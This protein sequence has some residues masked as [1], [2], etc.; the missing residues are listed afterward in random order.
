M[1]SGAYPGVPGGV[2]CRFCVNSLWG[3]LKNNV[4]FGVTFQFWEFGN[5]SNF[6]KKIEVCGKLDAPFCFPLTETTSVTT[7]L[8]RASATATTMPSMDDMRTPMSAPPPEEARKPEQPTSSGGSGG[9]LWGWFWEILLREN[10]MVH[11]MFVFVANIGKHQKQLFKSSRVSWFFYRDFTKKRQKH[12]RNPRIL[13]GSLVSVVSYV[14]DGNLMH[15]SFF[16]LPSGWQ[17]VK[18]VQDMFD[19]IP[20][21]ILCFFVSQHGQICR[22]SKFAFCIGN[23]LNHRQTTHPKNQDHPDIICFSVFLASEL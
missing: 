11:P 14:F 7:R 1:I 23:S 19:K 15:H 18:M 5:F 12:S 17:S 10:K 13:Q 20:F 6:W 16:L 3:N 4:L 21:A 9:L 22:K 8:T 2:L